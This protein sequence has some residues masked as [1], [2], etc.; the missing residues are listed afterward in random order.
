MIPSRPKHRSGCNMLMLAVLLAV[1]AAAGYAAYT[2]RSGPPTPSSTA[3]P[4]T[5]PPP[6]PDH[7]NQL[8]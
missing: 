6:S 1:V 2:Y 7:L 8:P 4:E 5:L 3:A